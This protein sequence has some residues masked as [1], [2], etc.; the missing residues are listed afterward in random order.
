VK[1][2]INAVGDE[3]NAAQGNQSIL[4][5]LFSALYDSRR[6][7]AERTLLRYRDV[8]GQAQRGIPRALIAHC[9]TVDLE[10]EQ[11]CR[12]DESHPRSAI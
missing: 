12:L 6:R 9:G 3:P 10:P 1:Q 5:L 7:Q 8:I 4:V 2:L 11:A